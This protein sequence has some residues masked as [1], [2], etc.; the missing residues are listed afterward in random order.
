M[1]KNIRKGNNYIWLIISLA[2]LILGLLARNSIVILGGVVLLITFWIWGRGRVN[3]V[4]RVD[5]VD[6][7]GKLTAGKVNKKVNKIKRKKN[8][9]KRKKDEQEVKISEP[10]AVDEDAVDEEK[11]PEVYNLDDELRRWKE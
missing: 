9:R 6:G 5:K 7:F 11:E 4:N 8:Q 1:Q 2:V 10:V 3:R